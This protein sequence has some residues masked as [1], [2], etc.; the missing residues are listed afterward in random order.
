MIKN[1]KDLDIWNK[2]IALVKDI[3][4]TTK[5]FPKDEIYGLSNQI[6]RSAVSIPS[7]IAEGFMR[8]HTNEMIQFLYITLG[9][10]GE[11]D[12]QLIVAKELAYIGEQV[13]VK[14]NEELNSLMKMVRNL[15]K[16]LRL[17]RTKH[18]TPNTKH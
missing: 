14:I 4:K 18:Q 3:Y 2:G 5:N 12:T 17:R 11:L 1:Y 8:Q 6:R 9:S 16:S 7:N 15:I 10:C 13:F